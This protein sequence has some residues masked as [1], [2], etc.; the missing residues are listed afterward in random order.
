MR[1][2][3]ALDLMCNKDR[4][5]AM[6][7][8]RMATNLLQ[9]EGLSWSHLCYSLP[10]K[11]NKSSVHYAFMAL[12]TSSFDPRGALMSAREIT[13]ALKY[14]LALT[15]HD[16][17]RA[18]RDPSFKITIDLILDRRDARD[19]KKRLEREERDRV[20]RER[21]EARE[22]ADRAMQDIKADMTE[23]T[24][25][26]CL[27]DQRDKD[28]NALQRTNTALAAQL[29]QLQAEH[30]QALKELAAFQKAEK[31]QT[32]IKAARAATRRLRKAA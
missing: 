22:R 26:L 24:R 27:L 11:L 30:A 15:W 12:E 20:E 16:L 19:E 32:A 17:V 10:A 7:G 29:R 4:Q 3:E 5:R 25:L 31:A 21:R 1:L 9:A 8:L 6:E 13:R 18:A 23:H 2:C 28:Y 14:G